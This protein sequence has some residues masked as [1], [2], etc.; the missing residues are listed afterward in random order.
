M[1]SRGTPQASAAMRR[2]LSLY[3][4]MPWQRRVPARIRARA[5]RLGKVISSPLRVQQNRARPRSGARVRAREATTPS[6]K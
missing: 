2:E 6:P 5:Q 3:T 1:R 4:A